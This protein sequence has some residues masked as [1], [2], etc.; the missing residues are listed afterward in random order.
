MAV[1]AAKEGPFPVE[2]EAVRPE[3]RRAEAEAMHRLV[4]HLSPIAAQ[5]GAAQI[6]VG[7]RRI[8]RLRR[9]HVKAHVAPL[10]LRKHAPGHILDR[11]EHAALQGGGSDRGGE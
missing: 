10:A 5:H 3:F 4:K 1:E 11:N 8:P 6:Q 2:I 7:A 9:G